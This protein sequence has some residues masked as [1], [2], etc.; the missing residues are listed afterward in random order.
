V[1]PRARRWIH[2]QQ[3][4]VLLELWEDDFIPEWQPVGYVMLRK[5]YEV[6]NPMWNVFWTEDSRYLTGQHG[7][8]R[9]AKLALEQTLDA[10]R[11]YLRPIN[12]P[13]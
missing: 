5:V 7:L 12:E 6:H 9:V 8:L 3:T 4:Y 10:K 1:I 2:F 11:G 13:A